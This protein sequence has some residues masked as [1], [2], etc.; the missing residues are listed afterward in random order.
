MNPN[1]LV[2]F[3]YTYWAS[4]VYTKK[5]QIISLKSLSFP[6]IGPYHCS[7]CY[8]TALSPR[9]NGFD[10]R[11]FNVEFVVEK[12]ALGQ[13]FLPALLLPCQCHSTRAPYSYFIHL[14]PTL[15]VVGGAGSFGVRIPLGARTFLQ[16]CQDRPGAHL[17]SYS[18]G[19]G[20]HFRGY[21]GQ[22]MKLTTHLQPVLRLR[23][24]EAV[25]LYPLH[26]FMVCTG[27]ILPSPAIMYNLSN[28]QRR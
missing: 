15:R 16:Y 14:L 26:A 27:T 4:L 23:M 17:G 1:F 19:S 7:D 24:S 28:R 22:N 25:H 6:F 18:M 13:G 2:V 12:V 11:S 3:H 10:S 21:S 9:T 20:V 5:I 8:F